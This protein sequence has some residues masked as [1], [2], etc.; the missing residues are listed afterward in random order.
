MAAQ[1]HDIHCF[2]CRRFMFRVDPHE[3][4]PV[5]PPVCS[6]CKKSRYRFGKKRR[7]KGSWI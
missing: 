2:R 5:T 3:R 7:Y 1:A 4:A 6:E